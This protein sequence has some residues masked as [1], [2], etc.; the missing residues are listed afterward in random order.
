MIITYGKR[1]TIHETEWRPQEDEAHIDY[2]Q[3]SNASEKAWGGG[4]RRG[5]HEL[6]PEGQ[7]LR[8]RVVVGKGVETMGEDKKSC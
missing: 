2:G 4:R 3:E 6:R 5:E 1:K 8:E 7:L